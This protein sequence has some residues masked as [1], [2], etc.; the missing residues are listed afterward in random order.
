MLQLA[1]TA[2]DCVEL[3]STTISYGHGRALLD[4]ELRSEGLA[5]LKRK[6]VRLSGVIF[7]FQPWTHNRLQPKPTCRQSVAQNLH[8][9]GI[10]TLPPVQVSG[11]GGDLL[12][13]CP[14][15]RPAR[16]PETRPRDP[17]LAHPCVPMVEVCAS[18]LST[19]RVR[20]RRRAPKVYDALHD[21]ITHSAEMY[22]SKNMICANRVR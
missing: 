17:R 16:V 5:V 4:L 21:S 10:Y 18:I 2:N 6:F 14:L 1:N 13:F 3:Y 9:G 22:V 8:G 11:D 12:S 15:R 20:T 19:R 7:E